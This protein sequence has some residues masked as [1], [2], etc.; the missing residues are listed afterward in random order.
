MR[1]T[2]PRWVFHPTTVPWALAL[3][4]G[5]LLAGCSPTES[6][7]TSLEVSPST[8][9]LAVGET[10]TLSVQAFDQK[11]SAMAAGVVDWTVSPSGV[12]SLEMV[13]SGSVRLRGD[14]VGIATVTAR[15]SGT[16]AS[17]TLN[18]TA[19]P[20]A[21]VSLSP[22][23]RSL[24]SGESFTISATVRDAAGHPI[25]DVTLAWS[26]S[27]PTVASVSANGD[28]SATVEGGAKG[29]ATLRASVGGVEGTAEVEV[30]AGAA[31]VIDL[32]VGD[33]TIASGTTISITATPRDAQGNALP[34]A[35]VEWESSNP[36]VAS[37]EAA[38]SAWGTTAL[39]AAPSV[40]VTGRKAGEAE[41][42]A[43]MEGVGATIS[44]EV[45][46]G[47]PLTIELVP[48]SLSLVVGDVSTVTG[49]VRDAA[50]NEVSVQWNWSSNAEAVA[51]VSAGEGPGSADV[52]AHSPGTATIRAE[53]GELEGEIEVQVSAGAPD[54]VEVTPSPAEVIVGQE[55]ELE[56]RV[57]DEHGNLIPAPQVTWTS[58][59]ENVAS[60]QGSG[61]TATVT[62]V[63][64]GGPVS[65]HAT[66]GGV[67]GSSSVTV[68]DPRVP[69][70]WAYVSANGG[71]ISSTNLGEGTVTAE[72]IGTAEYQ[73]I[74]TKVSDL[75][76]HFTFHVSA[77]SGADWH[78]LE[79]PRAH[80]FVVESEV[81][82]SDWVRAIV[83][84]LRTRPSEAVVQEPV[85]FRIA[86][87]GDNVLAGSRA[88]EQR[89]WFSYNSIVDDSQQFVP[90]THLSWTSNPHGSLLVTSDD[91]EGTARHDHDAHML[92]PMA[93][94]VSQFGG[95]Q[96]DAC[97]VNADF[98]DW[99]RVKCRHSSMDALVIQ[100][101]V[102]GFH[103]G[104]PGQPWGFAM[105]S[106]GAE[107]YANRSAVHEGSVLAT[108]LGRGKYRITFTQQREG[109]DPAI[110]LSPFNS[111]W[112]QCA[113]SLQRK[114]P[115]MRIDVVCWNV[116]G[117]FADTQFTLG[118]LR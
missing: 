61:S 75:G 83:L 43:S 54:R 35:S 115:D 13:G 95:S 37:V 111:G 47:A 33:Q 10:A 66:S 76:S 68:R 12:A 92:T 58:E 34:A 109:P 36:A 45:T 100:H 21:D 101:Y 23:F 38:E 63:N 90:R 96:N 60:V 40:I 64:P 65:I 56:A 42:S 52:Q 27:D 88:P 94:F 44:V 82:A 49:T 9:S 105:V 55:L 98:V 91:F 26:S 24:P 85:N 4:S 62:G 39:L 72:R 15:A 118:F 29:S 116:N 2:H 25:T 57:L 31:S 107:V 86:V 46:P 87:V 59:Q 77:Y 51:T 20:P 99:A 89:A 53:G 48:A 93:H 117:E 110:L 73:V 79:S 41:I 1:P 32:D 71:T 8:L 74:F 81:S 113:H 84:C 80:C 17:A 28:L 22:E 19:G 103:A 5:L 114:A 18:V 104:R 16:T 67:T 112:R 78:E 6:R 108:H 106:T 50:E 11:G 14:G 97:E 102:Q 30:T 70:A 7:L 69:M 3:V